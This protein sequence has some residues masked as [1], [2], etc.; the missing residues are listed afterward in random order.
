MMDPPRCILLIEDNPD[1]VLMI[2]ET[3]ASNGWA[4]DLRVASSGEEGLEQLRADADPA[5]CLVLLDL[6]LPG[7]DGADV[8]REIR[9]DRY[10]DR[11]IV[12]VLTASDSLADLELA[13]RLRAD[14]YLT[15]PLDFV[16]LECAVGLAIHRSSRR[17]SAVMP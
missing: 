15:K 3:L 2:R 5:S 6:A 10:L 9:R 1:D 16:E 12:L 17:S 8:L 11:A 13:G 4:S 7:I 14:N